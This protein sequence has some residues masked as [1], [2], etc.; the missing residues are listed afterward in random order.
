MPAATTPFSMRKTRKDFQR[1][2]EL[3]AD[4]AAS[5]AKTRK[6][7]GAYY[8]GGLAVECALRACVAKKTRRH[9]FPPDAKYAYKVYTHNLE[10]LLKLA[11]LE[12]HLAKDIT[13]NPQ[14]ATN[15]G[16]VKGWSTDSRYETSGL[17]GRD[18][19]A[20]VNAA[21]GVLQWIK[22]YW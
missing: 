14:L 16:I 12:A 11:Q 6:H 8:L 19:V 7:Q 2:A 18:M 10:E 3:R 21:D 15:W 22:R 4:E 5:L 9:E 20:A 17:N 13:S 1:L